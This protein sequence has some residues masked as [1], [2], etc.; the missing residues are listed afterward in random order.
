MTV[1]WGLLLLAPL[2]KCHLND[3]QRAN[4]TNKSSAMA[5]FV[6]DTVPLKNNVFLSLGYNKINV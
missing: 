2:R 1:L 6:I 5:A 3:S 4:I